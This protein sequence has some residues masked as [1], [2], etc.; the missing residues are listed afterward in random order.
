MIGTQGHLRDFLGKFG[1]G[2]IVDFDSTG[3]KFQYP[4]SSGTIEQY[5]VT[6][7]FIRK[8]FLNWKSISSFRNFHNPI[9]P[10][11]TSQNLAL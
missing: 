7:W 11:V 2:I 9:H 5:W 4:S 6:I 10:E 1:V 8:I 3:W